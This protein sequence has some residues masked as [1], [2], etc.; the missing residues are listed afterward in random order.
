MC[1]SDYYTSTKARGSFAVSRSFHGYET[2][3][4]PFGFDLCS[5]FLNTELIVN[6]RPTSIFCTRDSG[7]Y[8]TSRTATA[9]NGGRALY[10]G[11]EFLMTQPR[12]AN[13]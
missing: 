6:A 12:E 11:G 8:F 13:N 2:A 9:P 3:R 7:L 10:L 1:R 5:P 4:Q